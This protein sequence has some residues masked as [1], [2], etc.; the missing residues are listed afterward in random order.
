[1]TDVQLIHSLQSCTSA[2]KSESSSSDA[3]GASSAVILKLHCSLS[4]QRYLTR[5]KHRTL[6][7]DGLDR[8]TPYYLLSPDTKSWHTVH[9]C[10]LFLTLS[11]AIG[12]RLLPSGET[13]ADSEDSVTIPEFSC[14]LQMDPYLKAYEKDFK[15]R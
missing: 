13:M 6:Q 11:A 5:R 15:R 8:K 10:P 2:Y 7:W 9:A 14:L 3:P 1:M 4:Q 12:A